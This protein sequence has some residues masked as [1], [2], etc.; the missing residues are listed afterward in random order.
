VSV[1]RFPTDDAPQS[2]VDSRLRRPGLVPW[3]P[4]PRLARRGRVDAVV[5]WQRS[6]EGNEE[7]SLWAAYGPFLIV[8][9]RTGTGLSERRMR[10]A[11]RAA[12]AS[13]VG[14]LPTWY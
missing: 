8:V 1:V 7:Q 12:G 3:V 2:L 6:T 4:Q 9:Q 14:T 11:L 10:S 5:S 13:A